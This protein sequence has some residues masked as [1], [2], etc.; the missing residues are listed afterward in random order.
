INLGWTKAALITG[1]KD[2]GLSLS[3]IGSFPRKEATLV[4]FFMNDFLQKLIDKIN[5]DESL[6]TLTPSEC[7]SKLIRIPLEMQA[8]Y[9][10]TW[11]QALSIQSA[12]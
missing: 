8:P 1:A 7:I 12:N 9:I 10:S 3:I 6:K 5:S 4:E 11:P 2:V